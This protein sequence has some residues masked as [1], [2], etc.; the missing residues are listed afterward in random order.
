[1]SGVVDGIFGIQT[2]AQKAQAAALQQAG[3]IQQRQA[4]ASQEDAAQAAAAQDASGRRL[5]GLGRQQLA[6][7][8]NQLGVAPD[9]TGGAAS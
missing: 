5:R 7:Q 4:F 2:S 3:Q 6:F 9:L 8:G 1:M